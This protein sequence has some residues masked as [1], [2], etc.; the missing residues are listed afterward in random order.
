[1]SSLKY[2]ARSDRGLA[3]T[4]LASPAMAPILPSHLA[5]TSWADEASAPP[6][7]GQI[8]AAAILSCEPSLHFKQCPRIV[9]VHPGILQIGCVVAKWIALWR[10]F[11]IKP[12]THRGR[13]K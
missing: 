3:P 9:F 2:R 10:E 6:Q 11:G 13:E 8:L 1:M 7:F 5:L 12:Q 4:T